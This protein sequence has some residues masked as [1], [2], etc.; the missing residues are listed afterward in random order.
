MPG[1]VGADPEDSKKVC[2]QELAN[3]LVM[4][5]CC[6]PPAV[7]LILPIWFHPLSWHSTKAP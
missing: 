5:N 4:A 1:A 7:L 2:Y 3:I 6:F